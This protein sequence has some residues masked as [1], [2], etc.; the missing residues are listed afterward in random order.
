MKMGNRV[1]FVIFLT[2]PFFYAEDV[3]PSFEQEIVVER[4][5]N[6]RIDLQRGKDLSE[7]V[8]GAPDYAG[9]V[10]FFERAAN[11]DVDLWIKKQALAHLGRLY[12]IGGYGIEQDV[13]AAWDCFD[14]FLNLY[15]FISSALP[16]ADR[17][18][19]ARAYLSMGDL[20]EMWGQFQ[21]AVDC[22]SIIL[23]LTTEEAEHDMDFFALYDQAADRLSVLLQ[24]VV[25]Q[26]S[27]PA[28]PESGG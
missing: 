16:S 5:Q 27:F 3:I 23:H 10:S 4:V 8:A 14:K 19:I 28:P 15:D 17:L 26:E 13:V 18:L 21:H 11:Q 24:P 22:Y 9:A 12:Y 1:I 6:A 7:G 2:S 20:L 25:E